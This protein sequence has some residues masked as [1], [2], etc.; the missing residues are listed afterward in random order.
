MGYL[1]RLWSP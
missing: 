1:T